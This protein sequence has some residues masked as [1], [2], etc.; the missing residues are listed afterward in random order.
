M[1]AWIEMNGFGILSSSASV[2]SFMDAWIEIVGSSSRPIA[3]KTSHPSWMRGLKSPKV[4][5]TYFLKLSHPSW[6]RGLKSIGLY[7]TNF[8]PVSHP[9]WMRG[10]KFLRIHYL[11]SILLVASFMDAWIEILMYISGSH[12]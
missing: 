4:L 1:D 7:I 2:A 11:H 10:L 8:S 6:M 9:S 12:V 3:Y 5:K